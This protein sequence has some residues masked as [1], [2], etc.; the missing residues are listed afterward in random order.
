M[1]AGTIFF[2]IAIALM[3]VMH[4]GGHGHGG[5]QHGGESGRGESDDE[6]GDTAPPVH[7]GH[8]HHRRAA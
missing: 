1:D 5:H 3:I 4:M 2:L 8:S 6:R 7:A